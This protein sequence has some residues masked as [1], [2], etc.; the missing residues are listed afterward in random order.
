MI[1]LQDTDGLS[2][3]HFEAQTENMTFVHMLT[4]AGWLTLSPLQILMPTTLT[5]S[6]IVIFVL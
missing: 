5:L 1:R 3:F 6:F 2:N 4:A